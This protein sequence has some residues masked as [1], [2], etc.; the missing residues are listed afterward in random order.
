[1]FWIV[2]TIK[3]SRIIL[4]R[5]VG[6]DATPCELS[7]QTVELFSVLLHHLEKY[8]HLF[9]DTEDIWEITGNARQE[10]ER[11]APNKIFFLEQARDTVTVSGSLSR[12]TIYLAMQ[13]LELAYNR[14]R[15]QVGVTDLSDTEFDES[16][17]LLTTAFDELMSLL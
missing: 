14:E 17:D 4:D 16:Q 7:P 10:L 6:G 11:A 3:V 9:V 8:P 15:W 13:G 1:M 12:S 2:M 5:V